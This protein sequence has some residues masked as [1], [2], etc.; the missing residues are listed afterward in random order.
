M[1]EFNK[2][3]SVQGLNIQGNKARGTL[4]C[5]DGTTEPVVFT[6]TAAGWFLSLEESEGSAPEPTVRTTHKRKTP[7][8]DLNLGNLTLDQLEQQVEL[9]PNDPHARYELGAKRC[10]YGQWDAAIDDLLIAFDLCKKDP[11]SPNLKAEVLTDDR[12]SSLL[13]ER[14]YFSDSLTRQ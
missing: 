6:Q 2:A 9:H 10:A 12:F 13:R 11:A 8:P 14:P 4:V 5:S 1:A 3:V 7:R